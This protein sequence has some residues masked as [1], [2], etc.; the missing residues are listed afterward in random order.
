[1]AGCYLFR[2]RI[3]VSGVTFATVQEIS[4]DNIFSFSTETSLFVGSVKERTILIGPD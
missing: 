3:L 2:H 4:T 1:L